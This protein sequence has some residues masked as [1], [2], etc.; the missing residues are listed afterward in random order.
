MYVIFGRESTQYTVIYGVYIRSWPSLGAT[1]SSTRLWCDRKNKKRAVKATP[2][3]NN[4]YGTKSISPPPNHCFL[5]GSVVEYL[6]IYKGG[7][8][9]AVAKLSFLSSVSEEWSGSLEMS[10]RKFPHSPSQHSPTPKPQLCVP[11]H[12]QPQPCLHPLHPS[13][14]SSKG[15]AVAVQNCIIIIF[16]GR[17]HI[18][19]KK[20][21][22][23]GGGSM[24][25]RFKE[26]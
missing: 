2:Q 4:I 11:Q 7:G 23:G 13:G 17:L 19:T 6:F 24:D 5:V 3:L 8:C 22:T 10:G 25:V 1:E 15:R 26:K 14:S 9:G 21:F 12:P 16:R 18:S 20:F